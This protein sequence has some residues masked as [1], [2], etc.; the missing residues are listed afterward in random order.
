MNCTVRLLCLFDAI[1]R[2]LPYTAGSGVVSIVGLS[3]LP[4]HLVYDHYLELISISVVFSVAL[5][6][7]L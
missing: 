6:L 1:N 5:S 2:S 7:F 3:A 4:L